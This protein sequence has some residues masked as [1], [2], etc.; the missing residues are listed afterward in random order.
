MSDIKNNIFK[1]EN[2]WYLFKGN[3][4]MNSRLHKI[5]SA[6]HTNCPKSYINIQIMRKNH[7]EP[8]FNQFERNSQNKCLRNKLHFIYNLQHA[9]HDKQYYL[10]DKF[11]PYNSIKSN[12][13]P[14]GLSDKTDYD[15]NNKNLSFRIYNAKSFFKE[16]N[17]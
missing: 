7:L 13:V 3:Q 11:L 14:K 15:T 6:V 12:K 8:I 10:N 2:Q 5:H 1:Y 4:Y 9:S 17:Y 16:R